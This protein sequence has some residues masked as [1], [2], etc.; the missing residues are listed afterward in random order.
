MARKYACVQVSFPAPPPNFP[1]LTLQ[2]RYHNTFPSHTRI[3]YDVAHFF[4]SDWVPLTV[5]ALR[6]AMETL[7]SAVSASS[8]T[9]TRT[10]N[11]VRLLVN[12]DLINSNT[13]QVTLQI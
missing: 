6:E 13:E 10:L 1:W 8:E 4:P 9:M 12:R 11:V 2:Q 3:D 5:N 7:E